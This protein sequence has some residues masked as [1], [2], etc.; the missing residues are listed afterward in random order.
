MDEK[1][2]KYQHFHLSLTCMWLLSHVLLFV[3][4]WTEALQAPLCMEF[5]RQEYYSG[6][7][8]PPPGNL[9]DPGIELVSPATLELQADSVPT[10]PLGFP[11]PCQVII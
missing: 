3:T 6:L 1:C 4:L 5:F 8:F 10:E 7:P 9:P 2:L 11:N